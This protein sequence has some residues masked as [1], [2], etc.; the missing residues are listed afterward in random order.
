L[1]E[2]LE[3]ATAG[4]A[5]T[6]GEPGRLSELERLTRAQW[7]LEDR[8]AGLAR[9]SDRLHARILELE[10]EARRLRQTRRYRAAAAVG[11]PLDALRRSGR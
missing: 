1:V 8:A 7:R 5:E 3:Q 2:L 11:R 10:D 4:S 9:E 6:A